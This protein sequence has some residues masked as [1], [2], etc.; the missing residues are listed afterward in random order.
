M[1]FDNSYHRVDNE[2]AFNPKMQPQSTFQSNGTIYFM[3]QFGT[4]RASGSAFE[5]LQGPTKRK[6][7]FLRLEERMSILTKA[8]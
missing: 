5:E 7:Q 8:F 3:S 6:Q 1:S 4:V 2:W